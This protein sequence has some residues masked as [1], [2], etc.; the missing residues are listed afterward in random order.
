MRQSFTDLFDA[1]SVL[2]GGTD[3]FGRVLDLLK[4][5]PR[6]F[7]IGNGG[8]SAI[9]S[10]MAADFSKNGGFATF[11]F[12]DGAALTCISN[13]LGYEN[14]FSLPI[15]RHGQPN[16]VLFA[17]SSSGESQSIIKAVSTAA[18]KWMNVVTL[19][20][21]KPSNKL[22]KMGLVNFYVPSMSYGVVEIAHLAVLHSILDEVA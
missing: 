18:A 3:A 17:I 8:S 21:F 10:H 5:K 22:R 12:N 11:C 13:D 6:L 2:Q 16:D 14:V 19:S 7:F 15:I 9:A 1:L 20:G 4:S